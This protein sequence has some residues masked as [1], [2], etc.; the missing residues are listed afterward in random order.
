[1][2]QENWVLIYVLFKKQL[3]S[4]DVFDYMQKGGDSIWPQVRGK[5][6]HFNDDF[7]VISRIIVILRGILTVWSWWSWWFECSRWAH[8]VFLIMLC[9]PT[10][11][12]WYWLTWVPADWVLWQAAKHTNNPR[13]LYKRQFTSGQHLFSKPVMLSSVARKHN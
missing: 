5:I 13:S 2:A 8:A 10:H 7:V 6:D 1:M 12:V 9:W 3:S 11:S 4:I